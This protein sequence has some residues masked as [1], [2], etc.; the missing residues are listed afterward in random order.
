MSLPEFLGLAVGIPFRERGRDYDGCDCYG[1]VFLAYRDVLGLSL[2]SFAEAYT[3]TEDRA[4]LAALIDGEMGPWVEIPA[5]Q[6]RALD[7]V[8]MTEGRFPRHIG[9]V[10]KPGFV[11]HVARSHESRIERYDS[12]RFR[13]RVHGFFRHRALA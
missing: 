10:V 8:L 13:R 12:S 7:A 6:E 2:P 4:A 1:I 9:I 3:T 11:L 5:G